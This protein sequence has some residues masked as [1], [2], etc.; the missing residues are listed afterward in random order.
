MLEDNS[1]WIEVGV[2]G[3]THSFP[4]E[5]LRIREVQDRI[6]KKAYDALHIFKP[7]AFRPPM[8][9]FSEET[10][11]SLRDYT[12]LKLFFGQNFVLK[13]R[14][15][16]KTVSPHM[17]NSHTNS[18]CSDSISKIADQILELKG[19]HFALARNLCS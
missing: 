1:S 15:G 3:L 18:H 16:F 11:M 10:F 4:P 8:F 6:F 2:H 5:G 13:L 12:P 17:V 7:I 14:E 9:R 19:N